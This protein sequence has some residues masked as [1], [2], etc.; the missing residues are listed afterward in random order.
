MRANFNYTNHVLDS[1][2]CFTS[3]F[4][5]VFIKCFCVLYIFWTPCISISF[6]KKLSEWFG[7]IF[8][9]WKVSLVPQIQEFNI[10]TISN[11]R[12]EQQQ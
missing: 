12:G 7:Q 3:L 8:N 11:N 6:L 10:G 9:V 2:K 4:M 5:F 1:F